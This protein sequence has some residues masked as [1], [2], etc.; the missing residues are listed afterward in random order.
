MSSPYWPLC[1]SAIRMLFSSTVKPNVP[2]LKNLE[3]N[4]WHEDLA[5]LISSEDTLLRLFASAT[6]SIV[7]VLTS[8]IPLSASYLIPLKLLVF[9]ED[10]LTAVK[11]EV[12]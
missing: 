12:I 9:T 4:A 2:N 7:L 11:L 3:R 6:G 1:L 10:V 8:S 5:L